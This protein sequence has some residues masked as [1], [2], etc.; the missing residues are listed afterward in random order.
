[1]QLDRAVA[2]CER[3]YAE[4]RPNRVAAQKAWEA[5]LK[6]EPLLQYSPERGLE[7]HFPL[8]D[9]AKLTAREGEPRFAAGKFGRAFDADGK[10]FLEAG[11]A[12]DFGFYDKFTFAAWIFPRGERG[13]IVSRMVDVPQG[14]GYSLELKGGRLQL[15]LVK[16]WLD[17]SLRV[18]TENKLAPGQ[19]HHVAAVYDGSR[20]AA[21]VRLYV[22]GEPQKL[23]ILLDDLNQSFQ[24]KEPLR[25][26][27]GGGAES[28]FVGLLDD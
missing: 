10:R 28:R 16:R 14:E 9:A 12:G 1:A 7:T 11:K 3:R 22:N 24:T 8:D 19:W 17:D 4:S 26:A 6:P 21:G 5:N 13:T 25:L 23:R 2:D 15:N 20:V 18:E 27:A